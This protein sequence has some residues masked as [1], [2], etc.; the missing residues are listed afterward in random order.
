MRAFKEAE[1]AKLKEEFELKL[2][3]EMKEVERK[4][5]ALLACRKEIEERLQRAEQEKMDLHEFNQRLR[6]T[7]RVYARVKPLDEDGAPTI[8]LNA[9]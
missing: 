5:E 1:M 6:G 8:R 4:N 7:M 2:W 3:K 9:E